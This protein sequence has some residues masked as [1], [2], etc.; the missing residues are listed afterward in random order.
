MGMVDLLSAKVDDDEPYQG[1]EDDQA[2]QS[3]AEF[4]ND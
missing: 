3:A 4:V 1:S 2:H